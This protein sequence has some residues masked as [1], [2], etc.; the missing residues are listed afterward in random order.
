MDADRGLRR[1][2]GL[3]RE[4]AAHGTA[5][6]SPSSR[7]VGR[8]SARLFIPCLRLLFRFRRTARNR[9]LLRRP[10][11]E[12]D[13]L[14]ALAAERPPGRA[15]A[16]LDDPIAGWTSNAGVHVQTV[17]WNFTSSVA[18]AGRAP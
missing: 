13:E 2:M 9:P 12:V 1:P 16:P 8:A 14:A 10:R 6:R 18:C 5:E 3:P 7:A 15:R 17:S 11:A 4:D